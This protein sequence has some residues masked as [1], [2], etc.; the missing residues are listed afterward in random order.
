[1]S[2]PSAEKVQRNAGVSEAA[3]ELLRGLIDYA[4]LFPPASLSMADAVANYEK[5]SRS[6]WGWI[7]G[8]L[9]I[10]A[11]RLGEFG[12]A[13][14]GLATVNVPR[15]VAKWRVSVLLG[16][17]VVSDV[18]RIR[19]FNARI[20]R[21]G[22]AAV[23]VVD[24]VEVKV[25]GA[26]EI[27]RW[28]GIIPREL[29]T[30]FELQ[31]ASAEEGI[32]AVAACGRW[33]KIRTGGETAD[34]IPSAA[35]VVE[36]IHLCLSADVPF[37]ATAGLHHPLRSVHK[38]TYQPESP[39]GMMHGFLNVFLAAAFLRAGMESAL[40]VSLLEEQSS[41]VFRFDGDGVTWREHRLFSKELVAARR[42]FALSFGS[43]SFTEPI[44]DL[45]SLGLL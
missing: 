13:L 9:I 36:F 17:D 4:G 39:L 20:A 33:A 15:D 29:A 40:A 6:E 37:K 23:A 14:A 34:K 35:S 1:M 10:P 42:S 25:A 19:E 43:C 28:S 18:G 41:A 31:M 30:Y 11:A 22:L 16:S 3:G 7:L 12:E 2:L 26:E 27:A 21:S 32:P 8:R 24:S 5:Y 38:L 45:Q 44:D